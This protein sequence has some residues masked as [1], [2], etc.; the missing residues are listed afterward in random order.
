MLGTEDMVI[1]NTGTREF[2]SWG[3]WRIDKQLDKK[4]VRQTGRQRGNTWVGNS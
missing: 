2:W 3:R 1:Y 4:V